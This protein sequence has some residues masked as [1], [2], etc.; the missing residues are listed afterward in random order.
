ML[1]KRVFSNEK[2][3]MLACQYDENKRRH[4]ERL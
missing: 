4:K 3:T 1:K 2:L